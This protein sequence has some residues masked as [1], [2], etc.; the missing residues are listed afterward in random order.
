MRPDGACW[1]G[2]NGINNKHLNWGGKYKKITFDQ[3]TNEWCADQGTTKLGHIQ[4]TLV[5]ISG[6]DVSQCLC[7]HQN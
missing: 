6:Q 1:L 5:G 4:S 2:A 3:D 7:C